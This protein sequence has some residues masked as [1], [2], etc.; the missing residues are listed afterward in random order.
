MTDD[1]T[2]KPSWGAMNEDRPLDA[3]FPELTGYIPPAETPSA[4]GPALWGKMLEVELQDVRQWAMVSWSTPEDSEEFTRTLKRLTKRALVQHWSTPPG[5]GGS[6]GQTF[7]G[8]M[9]FCFEP[10]DAQTQTQMPAL[11]F[12]RMTHYDP[13]HYRERLSVLGEQ[14]HEHGWAMPVRP[15]QVWWAGFHKPDDAI[16]S[17]LLKVQTLMADALGTRVWGQEPGGPSMRMAQG[18]EQFMGL[19]VKPTLESLHQLDMV[20]VER[21]EGTLRW[22]PSMVYQGLC[23]Y[24]GIVATAA[25]NRRVQWG[26]SEP[27]GYGGY[28]EPSLRV[29]TPKGP[30]DIEIGLDLYDLI[31]APHTQGEH[32]L[33]RDWIRE[34]FGVST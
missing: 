7:E 34:R 18:L 16:W 3:L 9:L 11:G 19:S 6:E 12:E 26:V 14:A 24:I 4:K 30:K 17:S 10:L 2:R 32:P 15:A 21:V 23:D 33:L 22:W 20:L 27:D 1:S 29:S 13:D 31:A 25:L 28:F 8:I 5:Y